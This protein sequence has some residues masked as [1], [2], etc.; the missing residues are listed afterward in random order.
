MI[1]RCVGVCLA[2]VVALAILGCGYSGPSRATTAYLFFPAGEG[3]PLHV[4]DTV[5]VGAGATFLSM[6]CS[7]EA[8]PNGA[9]YALHSWPEGHVR[10]TPDLPR[11][12]GQY[13]EAY[14][15]M[16]CSAQGDVVIWVVADGIASDY[17]TLT[18]LPA[19]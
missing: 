3:P 5:R 13:G 2:V 19:E 1:R 17:V 4:G 11:G 8:H 10:F 9:E 16:V 7:R 18:I 14:A 15:D 6:D 12:Q